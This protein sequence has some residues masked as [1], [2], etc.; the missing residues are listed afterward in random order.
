L[1]RACVQTVFC[2]GKLKTSWQLTCSET[3]QAQTNDDLELLEDVADFYIGS[4]EMYLVRYVI[5]V[6]S[7]LIRWMCSPAKICREQHWFQTKTHER[8]FVKPTNGYRSDTWC[9]SVICNVL[10]F[11]FEHIYHLSMLMHS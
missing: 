6:L 9:S 11:I 7:F 3:I 8:Q 5:F 1:I 10:H 4:C 2:R